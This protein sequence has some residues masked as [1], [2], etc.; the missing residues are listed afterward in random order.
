MAGAAV[1]SNDLTAG[2]EERG[3]CDATTTAKASRGA[4]GSSVTGRGEANVA[5][6]DGSVGMLGWCGWER[7]SKGGWSKIEDFLEMVDNAGSDSVSIE[8][9]SGAACIEDSSEAEI[10]MAKGVVTEKG[11]KFFEAKDG[12]RDVTGDFKMVLFGTLY[13]GCTLKIT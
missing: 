10:P 2:I 11:N 8:K 9:G 5:R 6:G 12:L 4:V 3:W 1:W 13:P 7:G